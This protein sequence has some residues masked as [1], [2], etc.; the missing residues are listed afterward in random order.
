MLA[1]LVEQQTTTIGTASYV[2]SGAVTGRR[3]F[4]SALVSNDVV[5]Y[6]CTD[7]NG[8]FECGLGTWDGTDTIARTQVLSSSNA[9]AAVNW[10]AGTKR[11]YVSPHAGVTP[12]RTDVKHFRTYAGGNPSAVSDSAAGFSVGSRWLNES[13][14]REFV[15]ADNAVGAARWTLVPYKNLNATFRTYMLDGGTMDSIAWENYSKSGHTYS[16]GQL[17]DGSTYWDFADG[18]VFALLAKT[19]NATVRKMA[20]NDDH[21][22]SGGIY[23]EGMSTATLTGTVQAVNAANGDTKVWKIEVVA[24]TTA[25]FVTSVALGAAPTSI[26]N[27]AGMAGASIAA[28]ATGQELNIEVTGIAATNIIWGASLQLGI[29]AHNV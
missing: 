4:L 3:T 15:C 6:V 5:P 2:A 21:T 1:D 14:N 19:A 7:D 10:A 25:L 8:G 24:K 22:L 13:A 20:F 16:G 23:C 9:G 11:I 18:A 17:T 12:Y 29:A 26:Y 28:V 27:D